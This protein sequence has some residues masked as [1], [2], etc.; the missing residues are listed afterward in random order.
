[1]QSF[2]Y[3]SI[4][5]FNLL[6]FEGAPFCCIWSKSLGDDGIQAMSTCSETTCHQ[7]D[8][9]GIILIVTMDGNDYDFK[10][11]PMYIQPTAANS[12]P[13]SYQDRLQLAALGFLAC[14]T[15][16]IYL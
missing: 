1:M 7:G 3:K 6:Y 9:G 4:L 11:V 10:C 15:Q 14:W 5:A 2:G 13:N 8:Q 12:N 16:I